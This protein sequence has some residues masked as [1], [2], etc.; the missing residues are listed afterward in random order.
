[1]VQISLVSLQKFQ[2]G[3]A[4][5]EMK[6]NKETTVNPFTDN[7]IITFELIWDYRKN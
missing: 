5:T 7:T 3:G 6:L 1:M 4:E 2:N